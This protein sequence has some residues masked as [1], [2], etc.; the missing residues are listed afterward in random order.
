MEQKENEGPIF[1]WQ[2]ITDQ[3]I[4]ACDQLELGEL[5]HD[6]SLVPIVSL[7]YILTNIYYT[8]IY[9]PT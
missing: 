8:I 2:C 1:N 6:S 9:L 7:F 3:F 4:E 5:L